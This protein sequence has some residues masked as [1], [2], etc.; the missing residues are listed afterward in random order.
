MATAEAVK[1]PQWFESKPQREVANEVAG[2]IAMIAV[3]M[4]VFRVLSDEAAVRNMTTAEL[5]NKAVEFY[6]DATDPTK[7][8]R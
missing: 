7:G 4:N 5:L 2:A 6:L 1:E 8:G 3:P